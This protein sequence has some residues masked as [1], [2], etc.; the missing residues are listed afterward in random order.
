MIRTVW[1]IRWPAVFC[2]ALA[3]AAAVSA[4]E[5]DASWQA[6]T[7]CRASLERLEATQLVVAARGDSLAQE[8]ARARARDDAEGERTLLARGEAVV[9]SLRIL[10]AAALAQE[11]L[12]DAARGRALESLE[13]ALAGRTG[14][15]Q[16]GQ[17]VE[18]LLVRRE[19]LLEVSAQAPSAEFDLPPVSEDAPPGMLRERAA[20]ARDLGDRADRWL[21]LVKAEE[22]SLA[23]RRLAAERARLVSDQ[24][25]FEEP[26]SVHAEGAGWPAGAGQAGWFALLLERMPGGPGVAGGDME[27]VLALL[28]GWLK[29]KKEEMVRRAEEWEERAGRSEEQP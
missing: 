15:E 16:A 5:P 26:A 3:Y 25:F 1:D 18:S 11:L 9:D 4:Q 27:R 2:L 19:R 12:C 17:G 23:R 28:E 13:A 29:A 24:A 7:E 6:W 14:G 22:R 8:R 21:E 20:Y 10:A